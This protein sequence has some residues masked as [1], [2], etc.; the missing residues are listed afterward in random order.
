[1]LSSLQT[2]AVRKPISY[3]NPTTDATDH[4]DKEGAQML[5]YPCYP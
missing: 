4:T 1:M 5:F 2:C 3:T